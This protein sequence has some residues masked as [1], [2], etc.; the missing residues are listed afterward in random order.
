LNNQLKHANFWQRAFLALGI[1]WGL[2]RLF[3]T[4]WHKTIP[5]LEEVNLLACL[6]AIAVIL[7]NYQESINTADQ[8]F[9]YHQMLERMKE[10]EDQLLQSQTKDEFLKTVQNCEDVL[11]AQNNEWSIRLR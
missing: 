10:I 7:A 5:F 9:Q 8:H 1:I 11:A 4:L 6:A 3:S 2:L